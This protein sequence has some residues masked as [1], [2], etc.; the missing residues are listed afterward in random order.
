[1]TSSMIVWGA[2]LPSPLPPT[3]VKLVT[4]IFLNTP[5]KASKNGAME[6]FQKHLSKKTY[7]DSVRKAIIYGIWTMTA[8]SSP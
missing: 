8:P 5:L 3:P 4:I 6:K 7:E 1:M 2:R